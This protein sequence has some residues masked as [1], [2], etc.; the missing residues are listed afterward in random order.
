MPLLIYSFFLFLTPQAYSEC[1]CDCSQ[2]QN[3]KEVLSRSQI[4]EAL[5]TLKEVCPENKTCTNEEKLAAIEKILFG[6]AETVIPEE[7]DKQF[8]QLLKDRI[9]IG[10]RVLTGSYNLDFD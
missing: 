10:L 5:E 6:V 8:L 1:K 3:A 4:L 2:K 7:K 9:G